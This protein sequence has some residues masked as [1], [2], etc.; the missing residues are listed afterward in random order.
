MDAVTESYR[1]PVGRVRMAVYPQNTGATDTAGTLVLWA[2]RTECTSVH[3]SSVITSLGA[4][5]SV[6][7]Q[8]AW[9][10]K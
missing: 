6:V 10:K 1:L 3:L 4:I 5:C 2:V 7:T 9:G 8:S